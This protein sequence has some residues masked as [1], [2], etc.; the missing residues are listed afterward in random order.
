LMIVVS[1]TPHMPDIQTSEEL[2]ELERQLKIA[3]M[4]KERAAQHREQALLRDVEAYV[5]V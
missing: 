5:H 4:N 2:R 3:Y 1:L